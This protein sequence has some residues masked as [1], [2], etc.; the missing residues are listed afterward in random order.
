MK[1]ELE[2]GL[3]SISCEKQFIFYHEG[4]LQQ[5]ILF[6]EAMISFGGVKVTHIYFKSHISGLQWII[7]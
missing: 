5:E 1:E 4:I 7:S 3:T 2:H 6:P